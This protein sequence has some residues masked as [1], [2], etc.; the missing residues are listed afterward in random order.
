M[1][2][3]KK[4]VEVRVDEK[5]KDS[6]DLKLTKAGISRTRYVTVVGMFSA[7]SFVLQLLEFP[8]AFIIPSF[9]KMDFSDLPALLAAFSLG[10]MAGVM[11]ALVKNL[12]HSFY[13]MSM[14]VGELANFALCAAFVWTAGMIYKYRKTRKGALAAS[15]IG[16]VV[17]AGISYPI[18]FFV[19]YPFYETAYHL[20]EEV[21]IG[22]YKAILPSVNTLTECL[23]IFNMPFTFAKAI[24]S[25]VLTW[26][27]YKPL[28][29]VIK[30]KYRKQ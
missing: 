2:K 12:L 23:L 3:E 15:L 20:P 1:E 16:A 11:V 9:V 14:G 6:K 25:V 5:A 19:T 28:S 22:M 26:L 4:V 24:T 29:P 18:N 7:V 13:S 10:P 27:I 17:M 21:I 30:G 8:L